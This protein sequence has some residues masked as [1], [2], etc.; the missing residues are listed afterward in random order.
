MIKN[1]KVIIIGAGPAGMFAAYELADKFNVEIIDKGKNIDKRKSILC[2]VGGAGAFSDGTLNLRPDFVGGDLLRFMDIDKGWN[3]INCVDKIFIKYGAPKE[4]QSYQKQDVQKLKLKA[5][6]T[7]AK[8][9]EIPQRHIGSDFAPKLIQN[10]KNDLEKKGVK[11]T[12]NKEVKG[13]VVEK[14]ICKGIILNN[15]KKLLADFIILAPGRSGFKTVN[16]WIKKY[17]IDYAFSSIDVGVRVEV[18]AIIM[19]QITDINRDP[20]F[21]INT[22]T[23]DDSVRTFCVNKNGFVTKE[24]YD[25]FVTTNGHCFRNKKSDNTN[26]AFLVNINLT[27]PVENTTAYGNSIA[28]LANTI[29]GGNPILQRVGD[30]K[31]GRRSYWKQIKRNYVENTLKQATPGDISMALPHRVVTNIIE[32]LDILNKIIPGVSS[33]STLLYAPEIKFY[34]ICLKTN[35]SLETSIKNLFVAGDGAGL[36]RDIVKA[37]STGILAARGIKN[38]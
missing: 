6:A 3:L 5:V 24:H 38:S 12:L 32:G 27:E 31:R 36:S 20:K 18:P 21:Y 8:F 29:G 23:Y 37:A 17:K 15:K 22:P 34:A 19:K 26:F 4:K 14:N 11:F 30:L 13:L 35:N 28:Q 1:K 25:N 10:F 9:I 7:G 33:N 2:G 16:L